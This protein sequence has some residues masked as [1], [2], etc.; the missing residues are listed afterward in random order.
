MIMKTRSCLNTKGIKHPITMANYKE[1]LACETAYFSENSD[2]TYH[3]HPNG[4]KEPSEQ[5]KKTTN[6]FNKKFMF[7]GLVPSNKVV[8]YG[9]WDNFQEMLGEFRV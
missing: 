1:A 2:Y 8:V 4:S 6:K 3:T 5:D 9:K 7:I